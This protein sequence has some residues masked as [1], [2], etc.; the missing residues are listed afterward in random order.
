LRFLEIS[1]LELGGF[2]H[3]NVL[4]DLDIRE[5]SDESDGVNF[6][7]SFKGCFGVAADFYCTAIRIESVEPFPRT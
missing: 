5:L 6:Q 4:F 2:N 3:Q 1:Q 7:V